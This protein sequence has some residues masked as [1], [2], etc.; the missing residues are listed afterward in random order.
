MV[1]NSNVQKWK[2]SKGFRISMLFRYMEKIIKWNKGFENGFHQRKE[3]RSERK[4]EQ[5]F[6]FVFVF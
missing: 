1:R 3:M 6:A 5:D 4:K 2:R